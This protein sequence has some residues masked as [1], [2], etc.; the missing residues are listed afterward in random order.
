MRL[1]RVS[2]I[3]YVS[4]LWEASKETMKQIF[5]KSSIGNGNIV[6]YT[7]YQHFENP[8]LI[9]NRDPWTQTSIHNDSWESDDSSEWIV[10]PWWER[11]LWRGRLWIHFALRFALDVESIRWTNSMDQVKGKRLGLLRIAPESMRFSVN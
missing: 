11:S 9:R 1:A 2:L 3:K 6:H 5:W 7:F 10:D 4:S 8:M